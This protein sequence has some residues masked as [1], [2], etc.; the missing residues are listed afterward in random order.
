[1]KKPLSVVVGLDMTGIGLLRSLAR[2]G[3]RVFAVADSLSNDGLWSRYGE[4]LRCMREDDG[5]LTECLISL[6]KTFHGEKAALFLTADYQ[7]LE[8]SRNKEV[9]SEY[10][11]I[12]LPGPEA[13]EILTDK[14]LFAEYASKMNMPIPETF[15]VSN[16]DD[17]ERISKRVL[18]PC[19]LK[20]YM[21]NTE[22]IHQGLPKVFKIA[23]G[24]ELL[25]TF[26]MVKS[27]NSRYIIQE[28][29]RGGD[30][31]IY[32]CLMYRPM[33]NQE[34]IL[35][36]GKKIRQW[37]Q[38]TGSTSMAV[39]SEDMGI[40]E[41]SLRLFEALDVR[42]FCSVEYKRD[43]ESG[44]MLIMEPTVGRVNLQ[45]DITDAAG[46]AMTYY[47]LCDMLGMNPPVIESHPRQVKWLCEPHE[48]H[49]IISHLRSGRA[50]VLREYFH[51]IR[52]R[53]RY[54]LFAWD[55]P[56]PLMHFFYRYAKHAVLRQ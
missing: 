38:E 30:D 40:G 45:S 34:P 2:S 6:G 16:A 29:V 41:I 17:V 22:W 8:V 44:R 49:N 25:K 15:V 39:P 32:F 18:Y 53:R 51:T 3:A 50:S 46:V 31:D 48:M 14:C 27:Y 33:R 12:N 20:P 19:V 35:F 10:F 23:T 28:W 5:S 24:E 21:R 54:A 9:L 26:E 55:D 13:V 52:G 47:A 1:M 36:Y 42:G 56:L 7:A 11:A 37:P 43:A 4:K